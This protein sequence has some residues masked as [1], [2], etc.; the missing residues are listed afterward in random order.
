MCCQ[1]D[2][3]LFYACFIFTEVYMQLYV[4]YLSPSPSLVPVADIS[5]LFLSEHMLRTVVY[6]VNS[7]IISMAAVCCVKQY[8]DHDSI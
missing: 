6:D 2:S 7:K 8:S 4:F 1:V 5:V 3:T